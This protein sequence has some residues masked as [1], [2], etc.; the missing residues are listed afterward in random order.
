M[1]S[2]KLDQMH[3]DESNIREVYDMVQKAIDRE[4]LTTLILELCNIPSMPGEERQSGEYVY[5]WMKR[6]GF[7][8]RKYG[9]VE[10]RF[11]VVGQYGG[12]SP[13]RG[14]NLLLTSHLDTQSP[15]FNWRDR[16][17]FK[18]DSEY[19]RHWR[20]AWLE[21]GVFHGYAVENDRGPMA[22]TMIAA[23]ALKQAN[24]E[25]AGTLYV[26]ACPGEIGPEQVEEFQ[27]SAFLGKE[28]GAQYMLTHGGVAPD[29]AI[30]AEGTDFGIAWT[31]CGYSNIRIDLYGED[32]FTPLIVHPDHLKEH[33]SPL[34]TVAP[35][36]E[37]LQQWAVKYEQENTYEGSGGTAVPKVQ[38]GAIRGG[39]PHLMG[40]GSEVCSIY[41][42]V[43][44][45]PKSKIAQIQ[46]ELQ[47]LLVDGGFD[48]TVT[49]I[50]YRHGFEADEHEIE[51]LRHSIAKAGNIAGRGEIEIAHPV[52]SSMWRDHNVF[53]MFQIPGATFGP[54]RFQPSVDD[55]VDAAAIYA[56]TAWQVCNLSA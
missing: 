19:A 45:T 27:G 25:L 17:K 14:R 39:D 44:M 20:E 22:C 53:N 32:V 30:A 24:L 3:A 40:G 56:V 28:L 34:V 49:P 42:E 29:F 10:D 33:P 51:P 1:Q 26:T 31:A 18:P 36:I 43:N 4:E 11:N 21:N 2:T 16:W 50:V 6:E 55:M 13:G 47:T 9:M 35:F 5:E 48:G 37:V 8:P 46:R 12:M 52:F 7:M 41:L 38:I 15:Q 23:K 54:K